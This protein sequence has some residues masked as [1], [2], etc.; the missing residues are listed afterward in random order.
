[1]LGFYDYTVILTYIGLASSVFGITQALGGFTVNALICLM[2]SGLCDMFDGKVART[3][4]NRTEGE[5]DFGIQIDSLCDLICFGVFPAFI[6]YSIGIRTPFGIVFMVLY[7][8]GAVIRLAY[9]NV[10]E[11]QRQSET[12][13]CRKYYQGLPV[14][15]VSVIIPVLFLLK[16]YFGM[17][18]LLIYELA[19]LVIA[20]LF[21][22]DFKIRK[23]NTKAM[24]L[25]VCLGLL[26]IA[27]LLVLRARL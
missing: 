22:L 24:I 17:R 26:I 14:T 25:L 8:L 15:T 9:F 4:P 23:A 1:M 6:G 18:F 20:V 3:K 2:I 12:D 11:K 13:E 7:V 27:R 10:M 21:I 5:K 19:L 16:P